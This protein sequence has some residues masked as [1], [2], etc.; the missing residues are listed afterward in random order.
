MDGFGLG[1]NLLI[2][3]PTPQGTGFSLGNLLSGF[4]NFIEKKPE[5]FSIMAD[6]VGSN[7][8]PKNAFAGIGQLFGQSSLTNKAAQQQ[9]VER[10]QMLQAL[11]HALTNPN[12]G[13]PQAPAQVQTPDSV[14]SH[15]PKLSDLT[16]ADQPGPTSYTVTGDGY[17]VKG[18]HPTTQP[19]QQQGIGGMMQPVNPW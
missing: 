7:M 16:P 5:Q 11:N 13:T 1:T 9:Q 4:T 14:P 6:M 3:P 15:L 10:Q 17:S 12:V 18:N 8:A 19:Q 2:P